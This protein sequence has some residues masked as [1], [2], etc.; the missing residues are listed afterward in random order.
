MPSVLSDVRFQGYRLDLIQLIAIL[1]S[2]RAHHGHPIS[3]GCR[4]EP[5]LTIYCAERTEPS[6]EHLD[7]P[8]MKSETAANRYRREA[9]ECRQNAE[10]A[11][12]PVDREA[13][14]RLAADWAKLAAGVELNILA[15][16]TTQMMRPQ[17]RACC[18]PT[19]P[20]VGLARQYAGHAAQFKKPA[21]KTAIAATGT[22]QP[23]RRLVRRV[24]GLRT[25]G[26]ARRSLPC[27]QASAGSR[28]T[29]F[30]RPRQRLAPASISSG[31]RA[32]RGSAPSL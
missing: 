18:P 22:A 32:V 1:P 11:M 30:R 17:A 16:Q 5:P 14:L 23:R 7:D 25:V 12:R 9:E 24:G 21:P 6:P 15:R 29:S 4:T 27:P 31:L 2:Q 26:L 20:G 8:A 10:K 19:A 3:M 13:W 28:S